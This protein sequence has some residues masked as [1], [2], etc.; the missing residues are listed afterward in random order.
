VK[1]TVKDA[2]G[3]GRGLF[4]AKDIKKGEKILYFSGEVLEVKEGEESTYSADVRDHWHPMDKKGDVFVY[5]SPASP[6]KYMNH[7]CEPNA[8][9]KND[10][11]LI[12]MEQI[13]EGAEITIDY[14]TLFFE[15]WH[16]ECKCGSEHCR[17]S[18]L[19]FDTLGKED[20]E[21][22]KNYVNSYVRKKYLGVGR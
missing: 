18:I 12:A 10:R 9:L 22:L 1:V 13:K 16:M 19:T 17:K 6:W 4:A 8:G 15:G 3:K 2:G 7:S 5:I 20:Q 21:R 11:D 14:S